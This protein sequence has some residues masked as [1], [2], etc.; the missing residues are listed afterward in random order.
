MRYVSAQYI[1]TGTG[2]ALKRAVLA[3][4][5]DG[6]IAEII[7]N[8][9]DYGEKH[10]VEFYNGI[11]IP[12][13][14]NCHCH[15]ELSHM[16]NAM[17]RGGGLGSFIFGLRENRTAEP[18]EI[19]E[20]AET[21]DKQMY[22]AG[23]SA[24]ADICNTSF[25]FPLKGRSRINYI[26]LLEVFGIDSEKA[27]K[28]MDEL[29]ALASEAARAGTA[30]QL[31]PHAPYSMSLSLL[32]MLLAETAS[33]K[34]TSIHFMETAGERIFLE[35][36]SGPL[37]ESYLRSGLLPETTELA[38]DPVSA[39]LDYVTPS[40]N[41]VLV[42][43]TFADSETVQRLR[44]RKN[45]YWCLC[46]GANLFI[47]NSLPPVAMLL[48]ENCDIVLG[49]DSLASNSTLSIFEEMKI[50]QQHFPFLDLKQL[51]SWASANGARALGLHDSLGII[52][53]GRKP[54]LVL[55]NNAGLADMKL[56]PGSTAKRL[57]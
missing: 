43:N 16:H 9:P 56:L 20:R 18:G 10:S 46:P 38:P 42:H 35:S 19:E 30:F 25:T 37:H 49:T 11:I 12:G 3:L 50:L 14:V 17:Q 15:L 51:S 41:L 57:A 40:G 52:A 24:C 32:R 33:N 7:V 5:P 4:A 21:A 55:V 48:N 23:I 8:G 53:P 1:L 34:V 22:A 36:R 13:F 39:V 26:N 6:T 47:E 31:V 45:L 27:G 29:R 2:E 54:G 44:A 28:R